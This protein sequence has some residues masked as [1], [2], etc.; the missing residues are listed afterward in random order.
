MNQRISPPLSIE[1]RSPAALE[2]EPF[3]ESR[4]RF[5]LLVDVGRQVGMAH[6]RCFDKQPPDTR[7]MVS[8][9]DEQR[10]H[11]TAVEQHEADRAVVIIDSEIERRARQKCHDFGF[12]FATVVVV[13][14][15]VRCID[16]AAPDVEYA[17]AVGLGRLANS[18][19]G[20]TCC[21]SEIGG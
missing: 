4:R 8:G 17:C 14:E 3:I 10:F 16:C 11:V 6:E 13:Q 9:I 7:A 18:D 5:V 20:L 19:H 15:V 12:D 21:G 2:S 1:R